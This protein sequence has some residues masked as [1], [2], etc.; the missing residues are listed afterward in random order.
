MNDP[1]NI[2]S[3]CARTPLLS[4]VV[5]TYNRA[6]LLA[7]ALQ[8][9]V[10]QS[11]D[12][13]MF[14]ILVV[15]NNSSDA[16]MEVC[17]GF[18]GQMP[19]LRCFLEK[20]Q[21]LSVARNRGFREAKGPYVGYLDD[22]AKASRNWIEKAAQLIRE[23][24]PDVFGGPYYA[25]YGSPKTKWF[26]DEYASHKPT[27]ESRPLTAG[28][29]LSGTNMFYRKDLLEELGGFDCD[30]GMRGQRIGFGEETALQ[31]K[32]RRHRPNAIIFGETELIVFH[33]VPAHKMRMREIALRRY[34]TGK[35]F[36]YLKRDHP[37]WAT[38]KARILK[39]AARTSWLFVADSL[40]GLV[41]RD[42][43]RY[44]YF[45]NLFYEKSSL[46]LTQLGMLIRRLRP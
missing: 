10:E 1:Q 17:R 35:D 29:Y 22:D 38:G 31:D 24:S 32:I 2:S 14:E 12:R 21:G 40:R 42:R 15:D 37:Y 23:R 27:N 20:E 11:M 19:N 39:K 3:Q 7:R 30:L 6:N 33:L 16:T 25:Y 28:E 36:I 4:V 44:P 43:V 46:H 41:D 34:R 8:S 45:Q 18:K 5:C 26:K 13:S 9:L